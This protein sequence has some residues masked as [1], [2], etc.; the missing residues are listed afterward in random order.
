MEKYLEIAKQKDAEHAVMISPKD[1]FFDR[2][3][4]LKCKW[5]C[6]DQFESNRTKCGSR[7][8]SFEEAQ[9]TILAYQRILLIHHHDQFK[10]SNIARKIEQILFLDGFYFA[11][12]MH[13]CHLCK[14]CRIDSGKPCH[15][16]LKIRPCDQSFGIDMYR[17]VRNIGLPCTPLQS[18]D[19]TPNRYAFVLI[20]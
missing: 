5:G 20:D 13:C 4:I 2:R 18:K 16:P 3:A 6:E 1:I 9:A 14:S 11:C 10:L 17:T 8:L 7:G 12:A 19:E 15:M